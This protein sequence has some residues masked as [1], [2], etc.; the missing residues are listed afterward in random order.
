L[1]ALIAGLI[2]I[3]IH[4][5]NKQKAKRIKFSSIRFLKKLEKRRL[6]KVKIYQILLIIIRTLLIIL[7]VLAFARPTFS[8]AWNILQEPSANTTAVIILD[9]GLNMRQYDYSGNRFNRALAKLNQV[10]KSFK[11]E[12]RIRL[13]KSSNIEIDILDSLDFQLQECSYLIGDINS[14]L[15]KVTKYFIDNPNI[16]KELHIISDMKTI[17]KKLEEFALNNQDIKIYL[18]KIIEKGS[19]NISISSVVFENT[20]FE[21]N[22][23]VNAKL[24]L[25]NHSNTESKIVNTQVFINNKRVAQNNSTILAN[26]QKVI[27]LNFIPK[28]YSW[29]SGYFEINDD[30]LIADNKYYFSIKIHEKVKMLFVDNNPSS[31]LKS[32]IETI[33]QLEHIEIIKEN[34]KSLARKSFFDYDVIFLSNIPAISNAIVARLKS[35]MNNGGGIILVPG[36]KTILSFFNTSLSSIFGD[37]KLL[38]LNKISSGYYTLKKIQENNP[39]ISEIYK[40][41]NPEISL[42]KFKKYFKLSNI[43]SFQNILQ[44]NNGNPFLLF[45]NK[46]DLNL[47]VLSSYFDDSWSDMHFKGIF[48]PLLIKMIKYVAFNLDKSGKQIFVG[49]EAVLNINQSNTKKL[50]EIATPDGDKNRISPVYLGSNGIFDLGE[51]YKPGNYKINQGTNTISVISVNVDAN[52]L[53]MNRT[54]INKIIDDNENIEL[55]SENENANERVKEARFGEEIWKYIIGIAI[56]ILLFE[57]FVVK[58]IEGKI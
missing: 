40:K 18:E 3:L 13:L 6:K 19:G 39:I 12:D 57:S 20:L 33:N 54:D 44:L 9:D 32:A 28:S 46:S 2:P 22:K 29:N 31:Y 21:I 45:S 48:I 27:H 49:N 7:L 1:S 10:L 26:E 36:E 52:K 37:L 34:Y 42:P 17:T 50:Y 51:F 25:R 4:L 38:E 55:I 23:P 14:S 43:S 35:Y 11:P 24:Y 5:F 41:E 58:K 53:G 16:N 47:M 56:I 15:L 30:D 8:G